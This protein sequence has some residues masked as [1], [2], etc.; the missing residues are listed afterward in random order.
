VDIGFNVAA[1]FVGLG[2]L[3]L[4]IIMFVMSIIGWVR[5]LVG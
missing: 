3:W 2:I 5:N 4:F 1:Q